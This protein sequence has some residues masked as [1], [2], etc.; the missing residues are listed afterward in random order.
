MK[1]TF[2][3]GELVDILIRGARVVA[4]NSGYTTFAP[5]AG[6]HI[7]IETGSVGVDITRVAPREWPPQPGDV[8]EGTGGAQFF[9]RTGEDGS[10]EWLVPISGGSISS[11]PDEILASYGPL[12][13]AYRKGWSPAPA[14]AAEEPEKLDERAE[15][16]AGMREMADWLESNPDVPL[17]RYVFSGQLHVGNQRNVRGKDEAAMFAEL[18]RIAAAM[19]VEPDLR[20]EPGASHPHATKTFRGGVKY[21][22]VYVTEAYRR[23]HKPAAEDLAG[24]GGE[25][26]AP[27]GVSGAATAQTAAAEPAPDASGDGPAVAP[28]EVVWVAAKRKG[29]HYHAFA[30]GIRTACGRAAFNGHDLPRAEAAEFAKPCPRCYPHSPAGAGVA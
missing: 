20:D 22:A 28:D 27:A 23:G 6:A 8:W 13:L 25:V 3:A 29:I 7:T 24:E 14:P 11:Y 10:A 19:G 18:A 1:A 15:A 17:D 12:R 2:T 9:A 26:A 21:H 30:G 4:F 16:I 5:K